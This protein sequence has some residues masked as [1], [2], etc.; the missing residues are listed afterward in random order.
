MDEKK[1]IEAAKLLQD[2]CLYEMH[3]KCFTEKCLF[4]NSE[5]CLLRNN[6]PNW[7][8][9]K[10]RRWTD[11]DIA[12]AKALFNFGAE[13]IYKKEYGMVA[14]FNEHGDRI[15]GLHCG[16]FAELENA[17]CIYLREIIAEGETAT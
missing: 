11:A 1:L 9:P 14:V 13:H 16:A 17:D 4:A 8:I 3:G 15:G 10:P 2:F 12:L 7:S 6:P 5:R